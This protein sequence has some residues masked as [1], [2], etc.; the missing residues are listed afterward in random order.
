MADG[1]MF[2]SVSLFMV[3]AQEWQE[4]IDILP[5]SSQRLLTIMA[6]MKGAKPEV[7]K[8]QMD[9]L[10]ARYDFPTAGSELL[11][12]V[13]THLKVSGQTSCGHGLG[14]AGRDDSQ[15]ILKKNLFPAVFPTYPTIR[16]GM[17]FPNFIED[18]EAGGR[19]S[20]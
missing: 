14:K 5:W 10:G 17:L 16:E 15:E 18:K 19:D 8:R 12:P 4:T 2:V 9:L 20:T 3:Y 1:A 7:M 6:R 13:E 11:C